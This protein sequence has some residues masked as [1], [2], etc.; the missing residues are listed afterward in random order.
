MHDRIWRMLQKI[1]RFKRSGKMFWMTGPS[2]Y[3]IQWGHGAP[4]AEVP[5]ALFYINTAGQ[6]AAQKLYWKA[7]NN[8]LAVNLAAT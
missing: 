8:W 5:K 3:L 2:L 1:T 4:P 7:G 6:V